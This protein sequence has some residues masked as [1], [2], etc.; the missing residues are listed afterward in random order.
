MKNLKVTL[1]T[2]LLVTAFVACDDTKE[3]ESQK[4]ISDYTT[5]V[6]SVSN[7]KQSNH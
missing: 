4:L 1:G 6:D 7:L 3:K 2:L 5:Y